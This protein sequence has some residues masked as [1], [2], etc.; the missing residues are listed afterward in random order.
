MATTKPDMSDAWASGGGA[1]VINPGSTKIQD[2]WVAGEQ[3]QAG[4]HNFI[5]NRGDKF[6]QHI[7]QLG[8]A[9]WDTATVYDNLSW[10]K[11]SDGI[12]YI[13]NTA[14]NQGNDPT[15]EAEWDSIFDY[16]QATLDSVYA[17]LISGGT[18]GNIVTVAAGGQ[19]VDSGTSISDLLSSLQPQGNWNASTNTPDITATTETGHF[20]IV[21]VAGTT[22]LGG[23]TDWGVNDW[24]VKTATGWAKVDNSEALTSDEIGG[25]QGAAT[26]VTPANPVLTQAD[27]NVGIKYGEIERSAFG[28]FSTAL[29]VNDT[30]YQFTGFDANGESAGTTPDHTE[31]DIE[32]DQAG[33]YR[34]DVEFLVDINDG[35]TGSRSYFFGIHKNDGVTLLWQKAFSRQATL[36]KPEYLP[37]KTSKLV[38]LSVGDTVELWVKE[39]KTPA[40]G[41]PILL[42]QARLT[43]TSVNLT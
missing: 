15:T 9:Q 18:V 20:W 33:T 6:L 30:Y 41:D 19:V 3:P 28:A 5:W 14:A 43:V 24:A 17:A 4:E 42:R 31:D 25:I 22:S 36:S 37:F 8:I 40:D 27:V 11:G 39:S 21:S 10:A 29:P 13:S 38:A 12:V 34:I 7:N 2:G 26:P 32:I 35:N 23:I 16:F 1:S